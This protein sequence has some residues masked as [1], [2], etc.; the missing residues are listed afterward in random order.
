VALGIGG[1]AYGVLRYYRGQD[2]PLANL[3]IGAAYAALGGCA[4]LLVISLIA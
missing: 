1:A 3:F 2:H 4:L